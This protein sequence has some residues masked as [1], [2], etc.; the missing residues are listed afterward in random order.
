MT[1]KEFL[2]KYAIGV[3]DFHGVDLF[4]ANLSSAKLSSVNS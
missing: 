2:K 3:R 1:V 4:A